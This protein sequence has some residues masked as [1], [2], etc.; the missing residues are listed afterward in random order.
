MSCWNSWK[1]QTWDYA[2]HGCHLYNESDMLIKSRHRGVNRAVE[3]LLELCAGLFLDAVPVVRS[4]EIRGSWAVSR[5]DQM[6][7][8]AK[9][10]GT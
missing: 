4:A 7:D 3:R 10:L 6:R 9:Q 2:D 5:V 8:E 1:G